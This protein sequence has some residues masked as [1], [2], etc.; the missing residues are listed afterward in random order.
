MK[1][2]R[3]LTTLP[4]KHGEDTESLL[5]FSLC[6]VGTHD[7]AS[8]TPPTYQR[9]VREHEELTPPHHASHEAR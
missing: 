7:G 1:S 8:H 6:P 9:G 2:S 5:M 3:H 4:T